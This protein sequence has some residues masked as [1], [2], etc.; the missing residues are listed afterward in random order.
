MISVILAT[1][2]RADAL[3]LVLNAFAE[4]KGYPFEVVVAD[5]GSSDEIRGV[6]QPGD[7]LDSWG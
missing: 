4:Q 1:Y 2:E 5:D 3:D 7:V 6:V